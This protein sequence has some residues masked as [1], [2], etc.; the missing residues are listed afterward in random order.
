MRDGRGEVRGAVEAPRGE[1]REE[2][3][4]GGVAAWGRR[5]KPAGSSFCVAS[6]RVFIPAWSGV[7]ESGEGEGWMPRREGTK[8]ARREE[9]EEARAVADGGPGW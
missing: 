8:K 3:R 1:G 7:E 5:K 2:E 4:H 6:G 9:D